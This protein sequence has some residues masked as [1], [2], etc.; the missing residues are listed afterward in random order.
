MEQKEVCCNKS[1]RV[2]VMRVFWRKKTKWFTFC[3]F[4]FVI[5]G[6]SLNFA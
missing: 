6:V 1:F 5:R 2:N 3:E 4:Y